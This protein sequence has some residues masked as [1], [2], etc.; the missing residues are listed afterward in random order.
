[1]D[2]EKKGNERRGKVMHELQERGAAPRLHKRR[3]FS[4]INRRRL[5]EPIEKDR[6]FFGRLIHDLGAKDYS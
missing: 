3:G 4:E 2:I 5:N 1:V 6:L